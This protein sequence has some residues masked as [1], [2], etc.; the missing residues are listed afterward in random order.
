MEIFEGD[1]EG[2]GYPRN[3]KACQ[4]EIPVLAHTQGLP[5]QAQPRREGEERG[6]QWKS[7]AEGGGRKRR[8]LQVQNKQQTPGDLE[9]QSPG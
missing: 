2:A 1:L 9:N 3:E 7:E 6:T 4:G 5:L 8:Q